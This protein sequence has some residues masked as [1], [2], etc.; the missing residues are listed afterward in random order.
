MTKEELET[1]AEDLRTLYVIAERDKN[2]DLKAKINILKVF[3]ATEDMASIQYGHTSY[4][5]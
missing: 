4:D 2:L 5:K 3:E 1:M